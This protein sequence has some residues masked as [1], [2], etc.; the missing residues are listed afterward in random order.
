MLTDPHKRAIYD[1]VGSRGLDVQGW[2][3]AERRFSAQEVREEYERLI[4]QRE[5]HTLREQ[6]NP[7]VNP[8][9]KKIF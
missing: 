6:T 3:L 2:E 9:F 8:I 7:T 1:T 4:R 5:E